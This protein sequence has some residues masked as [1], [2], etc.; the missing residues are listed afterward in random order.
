MGR[1]KETTNQ[2]QRQKRKTNR[3][4]IAYTRQTSRDAGK[5]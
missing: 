5:I 1:V 2:K 3:K 4:P